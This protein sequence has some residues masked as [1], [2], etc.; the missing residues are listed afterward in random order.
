MRIGELAG[1]NGHGLVRMDTGWNRSVL[2]GGDRY[3]DVLE[4]MSEDALS[5]L[6]CEDR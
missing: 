6:H 1:L 5:V 3:V 4:G 2:A